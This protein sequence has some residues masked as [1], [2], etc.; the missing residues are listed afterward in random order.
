MQKAIGFALAALFCASQLSGCSPAPDAA[1]QEQFDWA[2]ANR[3]PSP[4]GQVLALVET[5]KHKAGDASPLHRVSI[6]TVSG[7]SGLQNDRVVWE[8][9]VSQ[10]P[11]VAWSGPSALLITHAPYLV[12]EYE[13]EV[14]IGGRAHAVDVSV[15]RNGP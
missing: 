14:T 11:T 6:Q 12:L 7:A 13:P 4:D 9:Q 3:V 5:G 8:S 10:P 2:I 15:T 1:P